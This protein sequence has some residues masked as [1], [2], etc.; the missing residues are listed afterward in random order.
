[1][2]EI[3]LFEY[4]C[5]FLICKSPIEK[6]VAMKK[7]FKCSTKSAGVTTSVARGSSRTYQLFYYWT[8]HYIICLLLFRRCLYTNTTNRPLVVASLNYYR[9][10]KIPVKKSLDLIIGY[11]SKY[12]CIF[13]IKRLRKIYFLIILRFQKYN[14]H[15]QVI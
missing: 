2:K 4:R 6:W 15:S 9:V 7:L 3:I 1:M 13:Q 12:C 11:S 14:K 5:K 10:V 8:R